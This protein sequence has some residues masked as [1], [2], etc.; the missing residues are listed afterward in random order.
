MVTN[1]FDRNVHLFGVPLVDF[2]QLFAVLHDFLRNYF[3]RAKEIRFRSPELE[4]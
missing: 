4:V 3:T 2:C 1:G